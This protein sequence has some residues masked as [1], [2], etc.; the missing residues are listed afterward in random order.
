MT[1]YLELS[2]QKRKSF[3]GVDRR[4]FSNLISAAQKIAEA[5]AEAQQIRQPT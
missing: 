4:Y 2:R 5:G 1:R 3:N